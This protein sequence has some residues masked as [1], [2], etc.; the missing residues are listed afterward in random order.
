MKFKARVI[1]NYC[2]EGEYHIQHLGSETDRPKILMVVMG[3]G[4]IRR[5]QN[6][7]EMYYL[8]KLTMANLEYK[9]EMGINNTRRN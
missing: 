3:D 1:F 6:F 5:A 7:F 9:I 8:G 2:S 4:G